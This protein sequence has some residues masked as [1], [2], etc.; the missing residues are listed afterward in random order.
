M[1]E[2]L[3]VGE[4]AR[5][6]EDDIAKSNAI[7]CQIVA[8]DTFAE[9]IDNRAPQPGVRLDQ[10]VVDAIGVEHLGPTFL[11]HRGYG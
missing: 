3:E 8:D 10:G 5:V 4:L 7:N 2:P 9:L 1:S 6:G 11:Q